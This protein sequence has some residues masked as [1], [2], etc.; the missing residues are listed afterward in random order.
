[1]EK[2]KPHEKRT[3]VLLA[4]LLAMLE[5]FYAKLVIW[6]T[7]PSC[8]LGRKARVSI[9]VLEAI[10]EQAES[11]FGKKHKEYI[12]V[13]LTDEFRTSKTGLHCY[14]PVTR[15]VVKKLV[16]GK[17]MKVEFHGS[18]I[19]YNHC[20]P[21]YCAKATTENQNALAAGC[22]CLADTPQ[23]LNGERLTSKTSAGTKGEKLLTQDIRDFQVLSE[24]ALTRVIQLTHKQRLTCSTMS[25]R[26]FF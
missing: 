7:S 17:V 3:T 5:G 18:S 11:G 6:A 22:I 24:D 16:H 13:I 8:S 19:C 12:T 9:L 2:R 23:M 10:S 26:F 25:I 4:M 15:P 14:E 20:C 1:M 21:L